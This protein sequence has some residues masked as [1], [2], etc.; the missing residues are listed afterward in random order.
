MQS[1]GVWA[2]AI[3][4]LVLVKFVTEKAGDKSEF[5]SIRIGLE[6]W[7]VVGLMSA[8]FIYVMKIASQSTIPII[9]SAAAEQFFG[10]V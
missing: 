3:G 1:P 7:F 2:I 4:L 5:A 10:A 8:T 9:S 6:S